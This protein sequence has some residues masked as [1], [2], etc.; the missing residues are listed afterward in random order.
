MLP[1]RLPTP[2]YENLFTDGVRA[3]MAGQALIKQGEM[4][5]TAILRFVRRYVVNKGYSP[6]IQEIADGV[7]L[8]SPNATRNHL[9]RLQDDGFLSVEPRIARAIALAD[10][11]P[12]G[13]TRSAA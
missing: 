1:K 6:T 12:D 4:R 11:A 2:Y 5:R 13:W 8:V 7:G 10:P 3:N 9:I